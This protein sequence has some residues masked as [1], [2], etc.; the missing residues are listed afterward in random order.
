MPRASWKILLGQKE[1][2]RFS[3]VWLDQGDVLSAPQ[4]HE[5][6]PF[7]AALE[8]EAGNAAG[9]GAARD[10]LA[11]LRAELGE[12][13]T[14][15]AVPRPTGRYKAALD[16]RAALATQLE[17]AQRR[18]AGA[19]ARLERLAAVRIELA[20]V[21]DP[22]TMVALGEAAGAAEHAHAEATTA[23]EKLLH[24]QAVAQTQEQRLAALI[25]ALE[26]VEG[27]L[28]DLAKLEE[29]HAREAPELDELTERERLA[30]SDHEK[31]RCQRDEIKAAL[32]KAEAEYKAVEIAA[33]LHDVAER[34]DGARAAAAEIETLTAALKDNAADDGALAALRRESQSL[35]LLEA[36]LSA[37]APTVSIKYAAGAKAKIT[38]DGRALQ[39]GEQLSAVA[40]LVLAIPGIGEV[41][42]APGQSE[43]VED[44]KADLDAH[45]RVL[46][47]LFERVGAK[48]LDEAE[49][50][51]A[52]RRGLHADLAAAL[53]AHP[54]ESLR[55]LER[56]HADL[57]SKAAASAD[58]ASTRS[59]LEI[60]ESAHE[61]AHR[62]AAADA[63]L[64]ETQRGLASARE[65]VIELRTR[66]EGRGVRIVE[67]TES[68]GDPDAR[69]SLRKTAAAA[70]KEAQNAMNQ[71]VREHAA[72][73]DKAPDEARFDALARAA[74][75]AQAAKTQAER[76]L[77]EL[78]AAEARIEGELVADRTDDVE[79]RVEE[80]KDACQAAETRVAALKDEVE[81]AQLLVRELEAAENATRDRYALPI[82][83]RLGPYLGLALPD[84]RPRFAKGFAVDGLERP[85]GIEGLGNLSHGTQEQ[86]AVLV[87]L[88]LA[89]LLADT[90]AP[91]PLVLDDALVYSDDDRIE[92]MF[93]ALKLAAESHQVLVFTCRERT[94][95]SL[96]GNRVSIEAWQ[97]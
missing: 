77:S 11:L 12:L 13:V 75:T 49:A 32:A 7:M 4:P 70:V 69:T 82:M 38:A 55:A 64:V 25:S 40:P 22:A 63:A 89:R 20:R 17:E 94:F 8:T 29:A 5:G 44:T 73:R 84:A 93:A 57:A 37:A 35:A 19:E 43:T 45:T 48:S 50:K 39:D 72:W 92:R 10:V 59:Q 23:R 53:K 33:R 27:K 85:T 88:G 30:Q 26:S 79:A 21:S 58:A 1:T 78:R 46:L 68:L 97:G 66:A 81:V 61:L 47:Q 83:K 14:S 65:S 51:C 91:A 76:Q 2:D 62:L 52:Q 60:E 56:A 71:A 3:M 36:R 90:G 28:A 6:A 54:P 15:H 42:I 96:G 9:C 80:L 41:T 34:L 74:Q 24:A 31:T 95:A 18:L 86:L 87:R 16:E 67:I